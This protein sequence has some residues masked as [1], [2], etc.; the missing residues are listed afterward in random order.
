M[1]SM[2]GIGQQRTA[3]AALPISGQ[4]LCD[5]A[6]LS[7]VHVGKRDAV[8]HVPCGHAALNRARR[9]TRL[10]TFAHCHFLDLPDDVCLLA[11]KVFVLVLCTAPTT[12]QSLRAATAAVSEERASHGTPTFL[13]PHVSAPW[14]AR[15]CC[16][17]DASCTLTQL[18]MTMHNPQSQLLPAAQDENIPYYTMVAI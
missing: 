12:R 17:T 14:P 1:R 6:L 13:H 16:S 10:P 4:L 8:D 11:G 2:Q 15:R 3:V 9:V 5:I 18:L 7:K